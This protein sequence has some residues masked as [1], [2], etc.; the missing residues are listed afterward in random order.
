MRNSIVKTLL[1]GM[2]LF[3]AGSRPAMAQ[4]ALGVG[5]SM[6][7]NDGIIG[8]DLGVGVIVD[9]SAPFRQFNNGATLNWVGDFS[10]HRKGFDDLFVS[11][12]NVTTIFAQAGARYVQGINDKLSFHGQVLF[13]LGRTSI[14]GDDVDDICDFLDTCSDSDF[15]VTPGGAISYAISDTSAFRAQLDFPSS[16]GTG[17]RFSLM[18]I[19]K[20]GGN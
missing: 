12:Y 18:Y 4:G 3:I 1:F 9:Y 11:D 17:R 16:G 8:T 10:F 5:L 7:D 15:V 14:G 20:L 6:L 19:M 2:F 13:G